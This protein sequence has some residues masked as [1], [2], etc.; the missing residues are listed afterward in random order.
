MLIMTVKLRLDGWL[1]A[2]FEI[3]A[4]SRGNL[5][6]CA[7]GQAHVLCYVL[8]TRA[9][10]QHSGRFMVLSASRTRALLQRQS[11]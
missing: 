9:V 5:G 7:Q 10:N 8:V 4:A 3:D 11:L 6:K 2:A 1:Q